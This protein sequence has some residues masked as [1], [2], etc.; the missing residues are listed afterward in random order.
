MIF[1][2]SPFIL[3]NIILIQKEIHYSKVKEKQGMVIKMGMA[4]AF[5]RVKHSLFTFLDKFGFYA[6]L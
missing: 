5:N 6:T 3:D 2:F 1:Q 4:N